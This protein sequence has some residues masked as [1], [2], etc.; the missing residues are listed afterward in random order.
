MSTAEV[1]PILQGAHGVFHG[2]CFLA[3]AFQGGLGLRIRRRRA[4]GTLLDFAAVKRHRT[5][6]PFLATILPLGYVAG[7]LTVYLH[8]GVW[9]FY[10]KHL[11]VGTI[12]VALVVVTTLVAKKT[13]GSNS[14]WRTPHLLLGLVI[15]GVFSLQVLLGLNILF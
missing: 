10:P 3:F 6:G 15:L 12:L 13:R 14:P 11:I 7:L 9:A 5:L 8:K 1:V 4:A 2:L